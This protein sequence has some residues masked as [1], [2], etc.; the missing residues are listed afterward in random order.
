M[1]GKTWL[2]NAAA[3]CGWQA[4]KGWKCFCANCLIKRFPGRYTKG[5]RMLILQGGDIVE[6]EQLDGTVG[7]YGEETKTD[8]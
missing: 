3:G 1:A 5:K 7:I 2:F 8:G 6:A 4:A